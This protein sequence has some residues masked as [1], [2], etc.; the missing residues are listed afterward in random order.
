MLGFL[1]VSLG[2]I[3]YIALAWVERSSFASEN[4]ANVVFGAGSVIGYAVLAAASWSWFRWMESSHIQLSGLSRVLRLFFVG[5]LLL[6]IGLAWVGYFWASR[7][8]TQP[9]DGH[10][11][12]ALAMTYGFEFFGFLLASIAF[13]D[14]AAVVRTNDPEQSALGGDLVT[15]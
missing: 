1:S 2:W 14:A 7:A 8:V 3:G 13:W 12:I 5:N 4:H 10:F 6:A 15:A 11:T 9:Y